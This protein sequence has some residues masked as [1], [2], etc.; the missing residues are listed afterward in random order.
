MQQLRKLVEHWR[1]MATEYAPLGEVAITDA[2]RLVAEW[3]EVEIARL[4]VR[5]TGADT[6][7][8]T[9]AHRPKDSDPNKTLTSTTFGVR[10][11]RDVRP[12]AWSDILACIE[13]RRAMCA[14]HLRG[15]ATNV[16]EREYRERIDQM[17]KAT[18]YEICPGD[19]TVWKAGKSIHFTYITR[20]GEIAFHKYVEVAKIPQANTVYQIGTP[21]ENLVARL[22]QEGIP[23]ARVVWSGQAQSQGNQLTH[24]HQHYGWFRSGDRDCMIVFEGRSPTS[25]ER[26]RIQRACDE[27]LR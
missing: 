8:V 5:W 4:S 13:S 26:E 20:W 21:E 11:Y 18:G 10:D 3:Y 6:A 1:Q 23:A 2:V 7:L 25:E 14:P 24:S 12:V 16:T 17:R 19:I 22:K 15:E 27:I 9:V